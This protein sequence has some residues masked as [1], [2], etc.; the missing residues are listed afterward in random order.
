MLSDD[1][2]QRWA[3]RSLDERIM[4]FK[5]R[6]PQAHITIYKLRKLYRMNRIKKKLLRITK[7][8]VSRTL[9]FLYDEILDLKDDVQ[10]AI[11]QRFKVV[12]ADEMLVTKKTFPKA[13]WSKLK[14]NTSLQMGDMYC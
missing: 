7:V 4:L 12:Y 9:P 13:D 1:T 5:R 8:P 11:I 10:S 2:L 6:Y 14:Q 3:G